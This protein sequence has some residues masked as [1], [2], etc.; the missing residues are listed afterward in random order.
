MYFCHEQQNKEYLPCLIFS[1][2][3]LNYRGNPWHNCDNQ[4][5]RI[6]LKLQL[7]G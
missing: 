5:E 7:D 3:S 6:E 4:D 2:L 1:G